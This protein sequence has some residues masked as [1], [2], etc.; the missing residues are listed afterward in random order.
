MQVTWMKMTQ[1]T[2]KVKRKVIASVGDRLKCY[3]RRVGNWRF[4][5]TS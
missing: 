3:G 4:R 5:Y 2:V 1:N